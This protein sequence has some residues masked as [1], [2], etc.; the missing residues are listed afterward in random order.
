MIMHM[1]IFYRDQ[2]NKYDGR[3]IASQLQNPDF[4]QL[5]KSYGMD[6][7]R[8]NEPNELEIE[9]SKAIDRNRSCLIEVSVGMMPSPW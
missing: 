8:I 7:V 5:A 2:L 3:V 4:V 1:V 6:A 9:L